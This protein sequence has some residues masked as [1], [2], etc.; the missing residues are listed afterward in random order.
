MIENNLYNLKINNRLYKTIICGVPQ[1]SIL[2]PQ[3]YLI[4]VNDNSSNDN[5]LMMLPCTYHRRAYQFIGR[6][7][8]DS[9]YGTP[10][11]NRIF[12]SF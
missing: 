10:Q 6:A 2:G 5:V 7:K 9:V 3:L 1:G 8:Y 4:Y 11:P 12:R